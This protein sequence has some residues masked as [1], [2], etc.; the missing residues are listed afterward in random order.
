[1]R[2]CIYYEDN[3]HYQNNII[4]SRMVLWLIY[5]N[6]YMQIGGGFG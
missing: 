1:M 2:L 4:K 5:R 3:Y 6:L